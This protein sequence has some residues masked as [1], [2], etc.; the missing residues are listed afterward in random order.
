MHAYHFFYA[1]KSSTGPDNVLPTCVITQRSYSLSFAVGDTIEIIVIAND[2]DGQVICV[3]FF[4]DGQLR[5]EDFENTFSFFWDTS[6]DTFGEHVCWSYYSPRFQQ[7][8]LNG[9]YHFG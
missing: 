8:H 3:Q 9:R 6:E 2:E 4:I 5:H 1:K 7:A